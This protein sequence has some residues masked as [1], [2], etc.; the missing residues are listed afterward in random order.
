[1]IGGQCCKN[2]GL[3]I[4]R[5][6]RWAFYALLHFQEC[7]CSRDISRFSGVITFQLAVFQVWV[8]ELRGL[9][10]AASSQPIIAQFS[11]SALQTLSAFPSLTLWIIITP[12]QTLSLQ[13][14]VCYSD[15]THYWTSYRI[16]CTSG[17]NW[18]IFAESAELRFS[19]GSSRVQIYITFLW[20]MTEFVEGTLSVGSW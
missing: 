17:E 6:D 20:K 14:Y 18:G 3:V 5:A 12:D 7:G 19:E 16:A 1:M 8:I 4:S 13:F 9:L 10:S 15:E 11:W 2:A